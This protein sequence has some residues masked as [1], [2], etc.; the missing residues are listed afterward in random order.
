MLALR[1]LTKLDMATTVV[2]FNPRRAQVESRGANWVVVD[3]DKVLAFSASGEADARRAMEIIRYYGM[4]KQ[5]TCDKPWLWLQYYLTDNSAP[6]KAPIPQ[7]DSVPIAAERLRV[8]KRQG[9]HY[10]YS[11]R[12]LLLECP[13]Q[14]AANKAIDIIKLCGFTRKCYAGN[15]E[16]PAM[17]YF[18][19]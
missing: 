14:S 16:F 19:K 3:G 13:S 9:Y 12:E 10:V 18:A 15:R 7:E 6:T 8:V 17:V 1:D 4:N 5:V 11:G 2:P